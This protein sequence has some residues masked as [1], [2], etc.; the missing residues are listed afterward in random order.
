MASN[1][2]RWYLSQTPVNL[3]LKS[4]QHK[5]VREKTNLFHVNMSIT[6]RSLQFAVW[7]GLRSIWSKR[8]MQP[9]EPWSDQIFH[10]IRDW[11]GVDVLRSRNLI[12]HSYRRELLQLGI[13]SILLNS[14]PLKGKQFWKALSQLK[15][16]DGFRLRRRYAWKRCFH[17]PPKCQSVGGNPDQ[18]SESLW[19]KPFYK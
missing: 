10:S 1:C 13:F 9:K 19:R 16:P 15:Q 18:L 7:G 3:S 4:Q 5:N 12:S 14:I 6:I 2:I 11:K 8:F 17:E